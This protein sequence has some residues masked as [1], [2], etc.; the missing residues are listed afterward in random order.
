MVNI[1]IIAV[2]KRI[3][4]IYEFRDEDHYQGFKFKT[5]YEK[6]ESHSILFLLHLYNFIIS[7][8]IYL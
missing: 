2:W 4:W 3:S 6:L 8:N 1:R 5:L 7:L